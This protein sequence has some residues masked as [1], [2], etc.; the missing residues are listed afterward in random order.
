MNVTN[1]PKRFGLLDPF[2]MDLANLTGRIQML[3]WRAGFNPIDDDLN[4]ALG[5]QAS[6]GHNTSD[7]LRAE[8]LLDE[9]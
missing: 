3:F 4:L 9:K 1:T 7:G 8:H 5:Q 6:G 2:I